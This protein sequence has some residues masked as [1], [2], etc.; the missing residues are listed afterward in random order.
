[1]T[2]KRLHTWSMLIAVLLFVVGLAGVPATA[3]TKRSPVAP[4]RERV[5]AAVRE[6][7]EKF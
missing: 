3:Q 2:G 1:M 5:E 4:N 6:A 7:Y